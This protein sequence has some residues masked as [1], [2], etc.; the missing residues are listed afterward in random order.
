MA[1]L[2]FISDMKSCSQNYHCLLSSVII[3]TS[4]LCDVFADC[5]NVDDERFCEFR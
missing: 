4:S 2:L 1:V 3:E 5:P